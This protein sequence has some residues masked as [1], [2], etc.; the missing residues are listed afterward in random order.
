MVVYDVCEVVRGHSVGL[1]ENIVFEVLAIDGNLAENHVVIGGYSAF[2]NVLANDVFIAASQA[3][4]HFFLAHVQAVFVVLGCA[5][6]V[7]FFKAFLVAEA[8]VSVSAFYELLCIFKVNIL[9]FA[10]NVRTVV[11]NKP[12]VF[13]RVVN[14]FDSTVNITFE[15]G[16]LDAQNK[17]SVIL[18]C[19]KISV[20]RGAQSSYMKVAGW[21]RCESCTNFLH[22]ISPDG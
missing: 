3:L 6:G 10:L 20:E 14:Y 21:R 11:V 7:N 17:L 4:R 18:L 5:L 1:D 13:Q 19:E 16:V 22:I 2:G 8:V 12:R 9:S 15:V